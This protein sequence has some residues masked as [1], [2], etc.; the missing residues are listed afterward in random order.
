MAY[1]DTREVV[2]ATV[3]TNTATAT[4][5]IE[6]NEETIATVFVRTISGAFTNAVLSLQCSPDDTNWI[7][8]T[9]RTCGPGTT[10][11]VISIGDIGAR[12]IRMFP[13]TL[14]GTPGVAHVTIQI[15]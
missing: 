5:S 8:A 1:G 7:T 3:N 9:T 11:N 14:E 10:D 13:T 15:K 4:T 12:Y 2:D 6:M